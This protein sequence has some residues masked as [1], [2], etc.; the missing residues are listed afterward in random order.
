[1]EKILETINDLKSQ[2]L[3][4]AD[5]LSKMQD[6]ANLVTYPEIADY[7][8]LDELLGPHGVCFIL[9][10][11]K[12]NFG[13]WCCIIK[14]GNNVEFFDPYGYFVDFWLEKVP[15]PY[16][17]ESGQLKPELSYLMKESPYKLSYNEYDFQ[18]ETDEG[19]ASCGRWTIL[20]GLLKDLT[21]EQ[22]RHLFLDLD[23]GDEI[24]TFVTEQI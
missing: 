10:M 11:W 7:K 24:A 1:M 23:Y 14:R 19:A 4:D 6:K 8:T 12:P 21:L 16:R 2:P 17:T 18:D 5:L 15:E 3:S 22:F 9:Y 20:R 13:H